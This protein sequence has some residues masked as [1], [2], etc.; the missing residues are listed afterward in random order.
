MAVRRSLLLG[1]ALAACGAPAAAP[2]NLVTPDN[3]DRW[4]WA[5]P[6][7]ALAGRPSGLA[8]ERDG[9]LVGTA[10][11]TNIRIK[12][13]CVGCASAASV[14]IDLTSPIPRYELDPGVAEAIVA[15]AVFPVEGVWRFAPL[16][17]ELIVR[18][19]TST[20][21]PVVVVRP[22]SVP[23]TADCG[24]KQIENALANFARGFNTASSADLARALNHQV[25]FSI[26]GE[27]LSAFATHARDEVVN[28]ARAR[29]L[30]GERVY[31]YLV[32]AASIGD[33]AVDLMVYFVRQA[34]DLPSVRGYRTAAAGSRLFCSDLLL[35]RFNADTLND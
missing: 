2:G 25:A 3:G 7:V 4:R 23:L 26:A 6:P 12:A 10:A 35:L 5:G 32:Y 30:A 20:Q 16:G 13:T 11:S 8:F 9:P 15:T 21:P 24:S 14:D 27:P 31:P 29:N 19:P 34:P 33:N 1:L 28:Y 18:S 22:W 17:G